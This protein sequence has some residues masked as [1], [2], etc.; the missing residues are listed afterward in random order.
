MARLS[1]WLGEVARETNADVA[2]GAWKRVAYCLGLKFLGPVD[3]RS[4]DLVVALV[5]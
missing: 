2:G 5:L 3:Q 4:M 1:A